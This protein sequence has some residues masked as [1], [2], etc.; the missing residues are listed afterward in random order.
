MC[1]ETTFSQLKVKNTRAQHLQSCYYLFNEIL[2]YT[3]RNKS[4]DSNQFQIL[5]YQQS[6]NLSQYCHILDRFKIYKKN[7]QRKTM[8]L[9]LFQDTY[10]LCLFYLNYSSNLIQ[11]SPSQMNLVICKKGSRSD[12]RGQ[13]KETTSDHKNIAHHREKEEYQCKSI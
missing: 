9:T 11:Y 3:C 13:M 5:I 2:L 10:Y 12:T 1:Q 4:S 7:Y 6:N 8:I